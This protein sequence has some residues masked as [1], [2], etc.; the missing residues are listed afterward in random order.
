M[1]NIVDHKN[2][3]VEGKGDAAIPPPA[4]EARPSDDIYPSGTRSP[5]R[6]STYA[7]TAEHQ[8]HLALTEEDA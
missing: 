2:A 8:F 1:N 5:T 3:T 7:P 4:Q 6:S